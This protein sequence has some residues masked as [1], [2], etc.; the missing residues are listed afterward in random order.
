MPNEL[1]EDALVGESECRRIIFPEESSR[2][3]RRTFLEWK[4]RGLIPY[5]KIGRLVYYDPAEVRRAIDRQFKIE[6]RA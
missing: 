6:P 4:S 5:R 1:R 2:P 3:S